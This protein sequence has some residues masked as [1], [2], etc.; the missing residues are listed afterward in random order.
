MLLASLEIPIYKMLGRSQLGLVSVQTRCQVG[1]HTE[2]SSY[3]GPLFTQ[4]FWTSWIY[5]YTYDPE[6][7]EGVW[8]PWLGRVYAVSKVQS[9]VAFH[10][11]PLFCR[12]F[13]LCCSFCGILCFLHALQNC[14]ISNHFCI[15]S[16]W[17]LAKSNGGQQ[18]HRV[19][20]QTR[21]GMSLRGTKCCDYIIL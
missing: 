6:S 12:T 2:V 13:C 9:A 20:L 15:C 16:R 19:L 4:R 7:Q 11:F 8:Y 3:P 21:N 17:P 18:P 5:L 10:A 14:S 1:Q